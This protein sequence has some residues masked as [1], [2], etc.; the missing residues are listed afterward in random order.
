MGRCFYIRCSKETAKGIDFDALCEKM[1]ADTKEDFVIKFDAFADDNI[2]GRFYAEGKSVRGVDVFQENGDMVVRSTVLANIADYSIAMLLI[3]ELQKI[4]GHNARYEEG[5]DVDIAIFSMENMQQMIEADAKLFF[6]ML[7]K[8]DEMMVIDG[9]V[10]KVY[11]NKTMYKALCKYKDDA[12]ELAEQ[13]GSFMFAL[14]YSIPNYDMPRAVIVCPQ[15]G[16]E[17]KGKKVRIMQSYK[18]YILQD[19]DFLLVGDTGKKGERIFINN[20]DLCAILPKPWEKADAFTVI[21]PALFSYE[22]DSFV[23]KARRLGHK[24]IFDDMPDADDSNDGTEDDALA[25][26]SEDSEDGETG[27]KTAYQVHGDHWDCVTDGEEDFSRI[28]A[29]SVQKADLYGQTRCVP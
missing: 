9:V 21:A 5:G 15:K 17:D 4:L 18:D 29:D 23:E 10:R 19:Y 8:T 16:E 20:E 26:Q 6:H 22:W 25:A 12:A 7:S 11:F 14:Q 2:G 27:D 1:Q 13:L 3:I 24:N 28:L